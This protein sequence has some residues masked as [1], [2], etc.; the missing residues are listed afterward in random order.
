MEERIKKHKVRQ[1]NLI[2]PLTKAQSSS[3]R[4]LHSHVCCSTIH[5]SQDEEPATGPTVGE[6]RSCGMNKDI[7]S[8]HEKEYPAICN[9]V[10]RPG[11]HDAKRSKSDRERQVLYGITYM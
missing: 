11:A 8:S 7:L 9:N 3:E 1:W 5:S 4:Q 10:D 6:R 2:P